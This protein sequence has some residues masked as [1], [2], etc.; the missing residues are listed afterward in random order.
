MFKFVINSS[1]VQ[2]WMGVVLLKAWLKFSRKEK[3]KKSYVNEQGKTIRVTSF[4][5]NFPCSLA[6]TL[7]S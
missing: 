4:L 7:M 2:W 1:Y 5:I 6:K 3:G